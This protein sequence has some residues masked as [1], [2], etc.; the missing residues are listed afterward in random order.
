[1]TLHIDEET[2]FYGYH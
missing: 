1:M 2:Q